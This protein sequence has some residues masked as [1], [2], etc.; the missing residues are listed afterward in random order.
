MI[1]KKKIWLPLLLVIVMIAL[2]HF[3]AS[4]YMIYVLS[5]V[6]IYAICTMSLT[7]LTGIG[8]QISL[9]Q[10]GFLGIGAYA[11]AILDIRYNVPFLVS[12]LIAGLITGIIGFLVGLPAVRLSGQYLAIA[13]IG[14]GVAVPQIALK[15][16]SLTGGAM[17]LLPSAPSI[18][19]FEFNTDMR[20]YYLVLAFVILV[21]WTMKNIEKSRFGRMFYAVRDSEVAAQAMGV[22][23]P[24]VKAFLFA[25]S[26][27]YAGIA[28]SLF[29]HSV[30]YISPGDISFSV[31]LML[32]GMMVV[33]GATSLGGAIA[34]AAVMYLVGQLTN[35]MHGLSIVIN[36][37]VMILVILFFPNGLAGLK[38][39][40][41][42]LFSRK[43]SGPQVMN[44]TSV[45]ERG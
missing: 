21:Y 19:P 24:L 16:E 12:L 28:G 39:A 7:L 35:E 11:S 31:S 37:V 6:G 34:G 38:D 18:G 3:L 20:I 42:S 30:Q 33:G 10:A 1:L 5:I 44:P 2:P 27:F 40:A 43:K 14:F 26:A 4:N 32:F 9:G 36:G 13:T 22:H 8:G 29:A 15:W 25:L 41:V 45:R 17:G 23:L